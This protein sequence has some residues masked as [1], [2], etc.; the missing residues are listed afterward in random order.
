MTC[1][2][3]YEAS[4]R[5]PKH[6]VLGTIKQNGKAKEPFVDLTV[7]NCHIFH[8]SPVLIYVEVTGRDETCEVP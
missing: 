7:K 2:P 6:T 5:F 1:F 8:S 3:Y 4:E